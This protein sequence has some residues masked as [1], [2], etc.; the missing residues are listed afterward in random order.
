[1]YTLEKF[2]DNEGSIIQKALTHSLN[3]RA[4]GGYKSEVGGDFFF[5]NR[6]T[7]RGRNKNKRKPNQTIA[8]VVFHASLH[9]RELAKAYIIYV[10]ERERM[11]SGRNSRTPGDDVRRTGRS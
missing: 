3:F 9:K 7:N 5:L 11:K 4:S 10:E 6:Y 8:R 1:M 2:I